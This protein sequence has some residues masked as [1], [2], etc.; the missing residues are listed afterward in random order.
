MRNSVLWYSR[1]FQVLFI[2]FGVNVSLK[3]PLL[4]LFYDNSFKDDNTKKRKTKKNKQT[5]N[6]QLLCFIFVVLGLNPYSVPY[7]EEVYPK[8]DLIRSGVPAQPRQAFGGPS[9]YEDEHIY[10]EP[11]ITPA[12][13]PQ[14][15]I[16]SP[17]ENQTRV[18]IPTHYARGYVGRPAVSRNRPASASQHP[19]VNRSARGRPTSARTEPMARYAPPPGKTSPPSRSAAPPSVPVCV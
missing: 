4:A 12:S 6:V 3:T 17:Q 13:L 8:D 2:A 7:D 18:L 16:V 19:G 9:L 14:S 1:V 11:V 5:K 10:E 15:H